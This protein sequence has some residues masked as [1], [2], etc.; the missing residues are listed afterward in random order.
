[1]TIEVG[2]IR[3]LSYLD[4]INSSRLVLIIDID[5]FRNQAKVILINNV[6]EI[7]TPRDTIINADD[8]GLKYDIAVWADFQEFAEIDLLESSPVLGR[9]NQDYAKLI[10]LY[11]LTNPVG[12][13]DIVKENTGLLIGDY[14]P[15]SNDHVS[16]FRSDELS[17]F[18]Q[19]TSLVSEWV[20]Q[21]EAF[22]RN[23][24]T[25]DSKNTKQLLENLEK[26]DFDI[27]NLLGLRSEI[28]EGLLR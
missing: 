19:L 22:M 1:M 4:P 3:R 6:I 14:I 17:S 11:A 20:V 23:L 26:I 18:L 27:E 5:A 24:N 21:A 13:L 9:I 10:G 7:A 16:N 2:Q 25:S 15:Q 28:L 12:P 8:S